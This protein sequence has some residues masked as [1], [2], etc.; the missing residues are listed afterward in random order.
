MCIKMKY[1]LSYLSHLKLKMLI[2]RRDLKNDRSRDLVLHKCG[3]I[4]A[5]FEEVYGMSL[6]E[7]IAKLKREG[8]WTMCH[9]FG[10]DLESLDNLICK[11]CG[12]DFETIRKR[13]NVLYKC[14]P[15]AQLDLEHR[16]S[17]ARVGGSNP[18]WGANYCWHVL[19]RGN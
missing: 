5:T 6:E 12:K 10:H 11:N 1:W 17:N 7:Y 13:D 3:M 15:V 19:L 4:M 18:S 14:A 16:A 9:E 2:S 8:K